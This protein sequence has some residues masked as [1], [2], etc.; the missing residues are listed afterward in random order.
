M[1]ERAGACT[2][3]FVLV[4]LS[5]ARSAFEAP[6]AAAV[7]AATAAAATAAAEA[8]KARHRCGETLRRTAAVSRGTTH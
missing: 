8:H 6:A 7:T 4:P 3:G 2:E 5:T 1:P